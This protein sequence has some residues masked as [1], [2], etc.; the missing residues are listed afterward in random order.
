MN[1]PELLERLDDEEARIYASE[2]VGPNSPEF[3]AVRERKFEE[4]F[5]ELA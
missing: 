2:L 1:D 4:L 3:E 5:N